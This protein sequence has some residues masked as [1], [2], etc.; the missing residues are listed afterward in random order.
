MK[1]CL[2]PVVLLALLAGFT[3]CAN[4]SR[5]IATGLAIEISSIER[6]SETSAEVSWHVKNT[7]IVSYLIS[8]VNHK[9]QLNGIPLGAVDEKDPLAV[10]PSSNSGRKSTLTGLN[11]AANQALID[12]A[13]T[14]TA[15]Y[16]V[17]SQLTILIYDDNTEKSAVSNSGTTAVTSR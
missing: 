12:A 17:D 14:G 16:R 7:N 15:S 13:R 6:T 10:P 2:I 9:I 5:I 3:A 11:A 8:R 4:S 1:R